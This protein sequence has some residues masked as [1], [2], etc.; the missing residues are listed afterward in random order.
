MT[1]GP[2]VR[3]ADAAAPPLLLAQI[4]Q[5]LIGRVMSVFNA[6]QQV[7]GIT[8]MAAAGLLAGVLSPAGHADLAGISFGPVAGIFAVSGILVTVAGLVVSTRLRG[9][10]A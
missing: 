9:A 8:S 4:P 7:A 1:S 3:A 2:A 5:P 6:V 10:P